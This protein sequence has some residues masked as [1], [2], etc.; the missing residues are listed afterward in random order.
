MKKLIIATHGKLAAGFKSTLEML[1]V[2]P[3]GI[4]SYGFYCD[5]PNDESTVE[6]CFEGL[7]D[8]DQLI[9]CT[10][11]GFGSVNQMFLRVAARHPKANAL[12]VTGVNLPFLLELAMTD[13]SMTA[14]GLGRMVS[15]ARNQFFVV[16]LP[17]MGPG[18]NDGEG[19]FE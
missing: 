17:A 16:K 3:D 15:M 1:G 6:R 2:R 12:I 4:V 14:E 11:I 7:G 10:D 18:S 13:G 19:F 5:E 9:V 8:D